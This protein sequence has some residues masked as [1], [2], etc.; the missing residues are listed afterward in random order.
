MSDPRTHRE[1]ALANLAEAVHATSAGQ[2][3]RVRVLAQAAILDLARADSLDEDDYHL[4]TLRRRVTEL[5]RASAELA[6]V[7]RVVGSGGHPGETAGMVAGIV[8]DRR[9]L[10]DD[11]RTAQARLLERMRPVGYRDVTRRR[12]RELRRRWRLLA[13]CGR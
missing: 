13:G 8:G 12:L 4:D 9:S 6:E 7:A 5:T 11:L 10:V 1:A 2:Y 3:P